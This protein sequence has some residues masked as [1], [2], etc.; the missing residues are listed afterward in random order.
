MK[1][2]FMG[3]ADTVTGSQHILE[4]NGSLV[5]RDCGMF[6]GKR[7][8]S[9]RINRT[10][11][12]R[13]GN[14]T[15]MELSHAHIDHCGNIPTLTRGYDGPIWATPATCDLAPVMLRDSARIQEQDANYLNQKTSRKGLPPIIPLY[16]INEAEKAIGQFRE[17]PLHKPL[18]IA[19]GITATTYE[20]GHILGAALSHYTLKQGGREVRVGFAVDLG[21]KNLPLLHDP[22]LLPSVDLLVSESTYGNRL[23]GP[24]VDAGA[25]LEAVISET[26]AR[27]GKV[28]IP[29]FA[30]ERAQELIYHI[31][32]LIVQKQIPR[33]NVYVDSPMAATVTKI[34]DDHHEVLDAE[35]SK[36]K[37]E[38]GCLLC[39]PWVKFTSDAEES[40]K[41]TASPGPHIVIA[42][43]GMCEH[44]RILHH[45]KAAISDPKNSVVIVGYQAENT[46]G[47]RIVNGDKEIKIHGDMYPVKAQISVLNAFSGHADRN[48][49]LAY[50]R[51]LKP[52]KIALV[53][54]E[55]EAREALAEAIRSENIAEVFL[56]KR[57]DS[58]EL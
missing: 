55:S 38:I 10:L 2:H 43:S 20:A 5:L 11:P 50:Y 31:T 32:E 34:F 17:N 30:L 16:S 56:P 21:R 19:P 54:G 6:Q 13:P 33:H 9:A 57:G 3:G 51:A 22:E 36:L 35:Y 37:H 18:E 45:L 46:L 15:A 4:C 47:R 39:P 14:I 58:L 53:H 8:E 49:L 1:I 7:D 41:V 28:L 24:A 44:G 27:G 12:F 26:F 42:A 29:S 25:Q 40:K 48:D 52:K 23:H